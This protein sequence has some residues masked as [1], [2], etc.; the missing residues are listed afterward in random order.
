M[1]QVTDKKGDQT[2]NG[3]YQG[4]MFFT[5]VGDVK[6]ASAL[7]YTETETD[8]FDLPEG[9]VE[10]DGEAL[11]IKALQDAANN[12]AGTDHNEV[13]RKAAFLNYVHKQGYTR[14]WKVEQN[15]AFGAADV[16]Y[17]PVSGG[18]FQWEAQTS[19]VN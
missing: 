9:A 5:F 7:K 13:F 2:P 10:A 12:T 15:N 4:I 19:A 18:Y 6:Y 3:L 17:L 16:Y 14:A 8:Q 1:S 11:L